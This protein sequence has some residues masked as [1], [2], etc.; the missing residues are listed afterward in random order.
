MLKKIGIGFGILFLALVA[1]FV[2]G[3]LFPASPPTSTS[4]SAQGLGITVDY[5]QPS[6]KGRVIFG[7]EDSGA[8]QPYGQY[9]R[10]GANSATEITF[11]SDV[12]FAGESVSAGTYRMYAVPGAQSFEISLNSE[13]DVF[14][15]VAEPDYTMDVL[16]VNVPVSSPG[17]EVETFTI[18]FEESGSQIMMNM[19]WDM[20]Q[21]SVPI[22]I[23]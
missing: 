16:K 3:M 14:L 18:S 7:D 20:T 17:V 10:L 5:S 22:S 2:Y 6:K 11:S 9:W 19:A 12:T 8:L 23:Q 21:I 1:F 13:V 15:G 4:F